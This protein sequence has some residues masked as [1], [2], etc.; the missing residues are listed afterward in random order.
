V[1]ERLARALR[2]GAEGHEAFM[3][4]AR[5]VDSAPPPLPPH[6]EGPAPPASLRL[7]QPLGQLH[8]RDALLTQLAE[9]LAAPSTRLLTLTGPPGVGKTRLALAAARLAAPAFAHGVWFVPLAAVRNP[10]LAL[11]A[12]AQELDLQ[13]HGESVLAR[14]VAALAARRALLV[15]DN[16]EQISPAA[17]QLVELLVACPRLTLLVT[18]RE[19]LRVRGERVVAVAPLALPQPE[20]T[21]AEAV[22]RSPAVALFVEAAQAAYPPFALTDANAGAVAAICRRLDGLPL[23][24]ELVAAASHTLAP[25]ALLGRLESSLGAA[26]PLL[27][28]LP[29]R[30]RSLRAA[31]DWSHELLEPGE[32][33]LL[34]Q[35]GVFAG[36]WALEAA[37]A[38]CGDTGAAGQGVRSALGALV[39]KS[40]VLR[41]ETAGAAQFTM[42][43]VVREYARERLR[44][45]G[46]ELGLRERHARY[47]AELAG[48]SARLI[49]GPA[50]QQVIARLRE[51]HPELDAALG[52]LLDAGRYEEAAQLTT[53]LRRFWWMTAFLPRGRRWLEALV[54]HLDALA[55]PTRSDLFNSIGMLASSV[56]EMAPARAA[57]ERSLHYARL[58][59]D[60]ARIGI[61][62]HNLGTTLGTLGEYD[63]A[64][65]LLQEALEIDRAAGDQWGVSLGLSS[66]AGLHYHHGAWSAARATFEESLALVRAVDDKHSVAL[67]LN[68]LGEVARRQG[69]L[70][71]AQ[72][73]LE[74]AWALALAQESRLIPPFVL[75]NQ[76]LLA[77]RRPDPPQARRLLTQA[78][79]LLREIRDMHELVTNLRG[80]ALYAALRGKADEAAHLL[81]AAAGLGVRHGISDAT[82]GARADIAAVEARARHKLSDE[83]W[84]A[85]WQAGCAL[86]DEQALE[87][88]R[89]ALQQ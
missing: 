86:H 20:E 4:L 73:F 38:I 19:R 84:Q 31:L 87:A 14:L 43:E 18:S 49:R 59:E 47:Y 68:N 51:A 37:E 12:I 75:N 44:E 85:R 61:A 2:I 55:V 60:E 30:Q 62:L 81:G 83:Q 35:L 56:G 80:C 28:D 70:A 82:A 89:V 24:L 66:L 69:D 50:Q 74:E 21:G 27:R 39:D 23:A 16:T 65:A 57:L 53:A 42:L 34:A 78:L 45:L 7:P 48:E 67:T 15:L 22:A 26:E 76:A 1:A 5:A 71:A 63:T 36:G 64:T 9:R 13:G 17:P 58:C 3:R 10:A 77:L 6:P 72:A 40:L 79:A 88:A 11:D 29:T 54:P 25:P 32:R 8:G 33:L 41:Q 46:E 52:Y